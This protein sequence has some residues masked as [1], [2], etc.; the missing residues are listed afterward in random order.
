VFATLVLAALLPLLVLS[1]TANQRLA[2]EEAR[3]TA[4][5]ADGLAVQDAKHDFEAS[6][7]LAV[8]DADG[9]NIDRLLG[10]WEKTMRNR[11]IEVGWS[12]AAV[13]VEGGVAF[14]K[15]PKTASITGKFRGRE[16][17]IPRGWHE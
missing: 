2:A 10:E 12:G 16:F 1:A 9:K 11:G 8:K 6:F 13:A 14:V 7:W 5:I 4:T 17:G 3:A 15:G